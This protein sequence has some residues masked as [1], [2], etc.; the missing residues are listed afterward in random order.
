MLKLNKKAWFGEKPPKNDNSTINLKT[1]LLLWRSKIIAHF[2]DGN[3]LKGRT[4]DFD[5][6]KEVFH[7]FP[8]SKSKSPIEVKTSSLKA[9]FFVKDY[10]GNR[11]YKK[12]RS[13]E[14]CPK[15][16]PTQHKII[17]HFKDGETLY[18]TAHSYSQNRKGFFVYPIDPSD[19]NKRIYVV[20]SAIE[21]VE[22]SNYKENNKNL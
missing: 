1:L 14:G 4:K 6:N 2:V 3:I 20:R 17:V 16:T 5:P 22:F 12:A 11:D 9:V 7:L 13:F 19:K 18:G 10:K 21:S 8:I 15:V